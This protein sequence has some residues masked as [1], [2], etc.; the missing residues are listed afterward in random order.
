VRYRVQVRFDPRT[1]VFPE[2][3]VDAVDADP[4]AVGHDD[5][6]DV[7]ARLLAEEVDLDAAVVEAIEIEP[8]AEPDGRSP[9]PGDLLYDAEREGVQGRLGEGA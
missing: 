3:V 7:F 2:F 9:L 5:D 1:G 6:H 8:N 4:G